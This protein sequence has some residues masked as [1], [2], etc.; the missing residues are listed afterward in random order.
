MKSK[1]MWFMALMVI[2]TIGLILP[3]MTDIVSV[4]SPLYASEEIQFILTLMIP[5]FVTLVFWYN[6]AR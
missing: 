1:I 5:I 3:V 4:T 2:V 6:I